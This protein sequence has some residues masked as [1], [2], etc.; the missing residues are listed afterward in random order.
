MNIPFFHDILECH[1][2][3]KR[4]GI[5]IER[6]WYGEPIVSVSFLVSITLFGNEYWCRLIADLEPERFPKFS[7][8]K[9]KNHKENGQ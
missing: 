9:G 5:I 1:T 8:L 4:R 7:L 2:I 3:G 6:D